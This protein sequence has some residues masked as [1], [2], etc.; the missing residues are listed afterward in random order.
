MK[1]SEDSMKGAPP[2]CKV[3]GKPMTFLR[4]F[5]NPQGE[6]DEWKCSA[7]GATQ[8]TDIVIKDAPAG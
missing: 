1:M 6:G 3:C 2:I 8:V 7:C 5:T 4:R